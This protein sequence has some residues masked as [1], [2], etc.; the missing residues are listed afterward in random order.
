MIELPLPM[1]IIIGP[2]EIKAGE[3]NIQYVV[4]SN[5]GSTYSWLISGNGIINGK[6][7]ESTVSISSTNPGTLQ[8]TVIEISSAG[9]KKIHL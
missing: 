3:S 1:P 6:T 2:K 7:D 9:C 5:Q 4:Q 8:L